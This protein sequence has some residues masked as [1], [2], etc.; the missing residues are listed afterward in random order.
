MA[1]H[2][3]VAWQE[4]EP[5][6]WRALRFGAVLENVVFDEDSREVDYDNK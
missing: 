5:D 6:I 3:P 4:A 1:W 2:L